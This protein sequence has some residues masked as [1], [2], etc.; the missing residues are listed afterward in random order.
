MIRRA[1]ATRFDRLAG[2][3]RNNPMRVVVETANGVEHDVYLKAS[4]SPELS[5]PGLAAEAL[6][7]CIAGHLGLPICEPFLVE[8]DPVWAATIPDA[9]ARDVLSKS[10]S[11]AFASKAATDGWNLWT[12]E[13]KLTPGRRQ[14]ALAILAFDAFIENPD[15]KPSNSNLLVRGDDF[16]IIDHEL[17]LRIAGIIPRPAPWRPGGL[18]WITGPDRHVFVGRIRAAEVD[19][20]AVGAAWRTLSDDWLSDF[21]ASMPV[22]WNGAAPFV[23]AAIAHV[24]AVRDKIEDCLTEIGRILG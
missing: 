4:G 13:E 3:G 12:P 5:I 9:S 15:R 2:A 23:E 11:V 16:R 21:E 24:R 22:E 20:E 14:M 18:D 6:A 19:L 10:D 7:A 8:I 1:V 17:S